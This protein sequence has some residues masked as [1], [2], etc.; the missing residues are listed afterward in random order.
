MVRSLHV[1]VEQ[2]W[3][4]NDKV[5]V[6]VVDLCQV[7]CGV[8]LHYLG[9]EIFEKWSR[10]AG[11][12]VQVRGAVQSA[13]EIGRDGLEILRRRLNEIYNWDLRV[14]STL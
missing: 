1:Q 4:G 14:L 2:V 3:L 13:R 8:R 9:A 5:Q 12:E 6:L 7:L 11:E 10:Y